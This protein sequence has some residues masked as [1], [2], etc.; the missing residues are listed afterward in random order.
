MTARVRGG[1]HAARR[2]VKA[3][4]DL[5]VTGHLHAPF[6]QAL[7]FGDGLTYAVGA[8]TLSRRER[9]EP[10]SFNV[11]TLDGDRLTVAVMAWDGHALG[12]GRAW[13]VALRPRP[14]T[15]SVEIS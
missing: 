6:V 1:A 3:G 11:I 13:E 7:P 2:L 15:P 14:T 5:I 8:G 10:P 9:G 4:A 12:V